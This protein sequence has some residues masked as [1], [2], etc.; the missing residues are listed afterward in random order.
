MPEDRFSHG[1]VHLLS[2]NFMMS[3]DNDNVVT[4]YITIV[5]KFVT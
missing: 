2:A 5:K 4:E 1:M 3:Q